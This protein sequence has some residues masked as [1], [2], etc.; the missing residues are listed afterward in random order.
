MTGLVDVDGLTGTLFSDGWRAPVAGGA[1]EVTEPA[2]G[3]TLA[4]V[5]VADA[6]D[7]A[8]AAAGAAREIGRAHV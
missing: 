8:K 2:T 7:V 1:V 4:R 3:K 6:A 5:G